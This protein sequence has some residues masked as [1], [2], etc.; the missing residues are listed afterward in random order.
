MID[1][2]ILNGDFVIV[3]QKQAVHEGQIVVGL[4]DGEA[5]V[6]RFGYLDGQPHLFPENEFYEPIPFNTYDCQIIGQVVTVFR[7][8]VN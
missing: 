6:K 2:G 3:E 8:K 7:T 5:T 1:A 4:I